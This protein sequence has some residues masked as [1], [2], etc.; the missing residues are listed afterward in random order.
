MT[1]RERIGVV[2]LVALFLVL[3]LALIFTA[4][5]GSNAGNSLR[6]NTLIDQRVI[7]QRKAR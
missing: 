3:G 5:R 2:V 6:D 7:N 4:D 1:R